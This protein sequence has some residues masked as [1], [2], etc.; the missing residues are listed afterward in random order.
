MTNIPKN[1]Y[2]P[3]YVSAPGATLLETLE[4]AKHMG[5]STKTINEIVQGKAAITLDTALQLE[6]ILSIP[7]SFWLKREQHYRQYRTHLSN[8][9]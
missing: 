2:Q 7:T 1:E 4:L 5:C 6:Q 9:E 8:S 3:D